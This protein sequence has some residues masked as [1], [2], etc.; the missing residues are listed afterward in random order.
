MALT[1]RLDPEVDAQLTALAKRLKISKQQALSL[2][3]NQFIDEFD[4]AAIARRVVDEILIR[5]KEL[6]ERLADA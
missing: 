4:S 5:D 3:V 6:L 2:A 1:L